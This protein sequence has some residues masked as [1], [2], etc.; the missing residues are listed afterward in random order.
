MELWRAAER[1]KQLAGQP[2]ATR[3]LAEREREFNGQRRMI[4]AAEGIGALAAAE[5]TLESRRGA[6]AFASDVDLALSVRD[7]CW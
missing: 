6:G 1:K 2:A 7:L 4:F 3:P 5:A